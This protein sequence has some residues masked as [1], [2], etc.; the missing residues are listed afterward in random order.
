MDQVV[1]PVTTGAGT[2]PP[3]RAA[4][5]PH[6]DRGQQQHGVGQMRDDDPR[7]E[8]ELD[9]HRAEQH[10]DDEEDECEGGGAHEGAVGAVAEPGH[11]GHRQHEQADQGRDPAVAELDDGGEIE[12]GNQW[13]LQRGQW[14]PQPRP[15]R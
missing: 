1:G 5:A 12:R 14:S 6:Q 7:R 9:G 13:P 4:G 10:L 2:A 15:S 11:G 3:A 8:L